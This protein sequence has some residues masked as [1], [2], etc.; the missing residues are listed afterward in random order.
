MAIR[1]RIIRGSRRQ[2]LWAARP[3]SNI[4]PG[5]RR[6]RSIWNRKRYVHCPPVADTYFELA[7]LISRQQKKR[8]NAAGNQQDLNAN[9]DPNVEVNQDLDEL[10]KMTEATILNVKE[11]T[12]VKMILNRKFAFVSFDGSDKVN[13]VTFKWIAQRFPQKLIEYFEQRIIWHNWMCTMIMIKFT[14]ANILDKMEQKRGQ[15]RYS[16]MC[17]KCIYVCIN[18]SSYFYTETAFPSNRFIACKLCHQSK[19]IRCQFCPCMD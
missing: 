18:V 15:Q 10:T 19:T 13:I 4:S 2:T 7:L 17:Y 16:K 5:A 3:S 14:F 1:I 9:P 11:V 8:R 12:D 6:T